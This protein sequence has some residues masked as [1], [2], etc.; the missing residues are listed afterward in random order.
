MRD[1]TDRTGDLTAPDGA[2]S[3][4]SMVFARICTSFRVNDPA[5][6]ALCPAVAASRASASPHATGRG[7]AFRVLSLWFRV[8]KRRC[9]GTRLTH[10]SLT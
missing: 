6:A 10:G 4:K 7:I 8:S 1:R 5:F 9:D 3:R 2:G